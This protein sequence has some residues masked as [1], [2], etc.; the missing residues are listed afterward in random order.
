MLST[1][2]VLDVHLHPLLIQQVTLKVFAII[3]LCDIKHTWNIQRMHLN[4]LLS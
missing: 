2:I 3:Y 1:K 4:N